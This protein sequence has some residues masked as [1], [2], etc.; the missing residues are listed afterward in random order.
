MLSDLIL[1]REELVSIINYACQKSFQRIECF[2]SSNLSII[3]NGKKI[4]VMRSSHNFF[5]CFRQIIEVTCAVNPFMPT[6]PTFVVRETDVS[7][8]NGRASGSP[9][10]PRDVSLSDSK[11]WNGG[12]EWVIKGNIV[13]S[14]SLSRMGLHSREIIS[15][16]CPSGCPINYLNA[17]IYL[18][19]EGRLFLTLKAFDMRCDMIECKLNMKYLTLQF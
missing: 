4:T 17:F 14:S 6:V 2:D 15:E 5:L 1:N 10:M 11:C 12:H 9:I 8:H 3:N 13:C 19:S 16:S 7:R 18:S